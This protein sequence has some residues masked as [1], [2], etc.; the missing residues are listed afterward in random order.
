MN[1]L[2]KSIIYRMIAS[3]MM[4]FFSYLLSN[5]IKVS[6]IITITDVIAKTALYFLYELIWD[7][8]HR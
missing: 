2:Y 1:L 7:K 3:S 4:M 5:D 8:Y 6:L